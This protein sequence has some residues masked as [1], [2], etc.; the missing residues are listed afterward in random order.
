MTWQVTLGANPFGAGSA[1]VLHVR[2]PML[3]TGAAPAL[4]SENCTAVVVEVL[5]TVTGLTAPLPTGILPKLTFLGTMV[6]I[7]LGMNPVPL[8]DTVCGLFAAL[9]VKCKLPV[10]G[11]CAVGA[12]VTL[13][14]HE[15]RGANGPEIPKQVWLSR[16]NGAEGPPTAVKV[17]LAVL[18]VLVIFTAIICDWPT[19]VLP[20]LMLFGATLSFGAVDAADAGRDAII[21]GSRIEMTTVAA[22]FAVFIVHLGPPGNDS[23]RRKM[24]KHLRNGASTAA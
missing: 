20:K 16:L 1:T 14:V 24:Q 2:P 17:T 18:E 22:R 23:D 10:N 13:A 9:S 3:N 5:V 7:G 15:A 19:M 4:I 21:A 11:P 12:N 8:S 6:S